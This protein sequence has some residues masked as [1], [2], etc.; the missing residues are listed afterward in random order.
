MKKIC[1]ILLLSAATA[2]AGISEAKSQTNDT[3]H[4]YTDAENRRIAVLFHRG[5]RCDSLLATAEAE[6]VLLKAIDGQR[7]SISR[8]L[9]RM[10]SGADSLVSH[11][12]AE[13]G[14]LLNANKKLSKRNRVKNWFIGGSVGLNLLLLLIL[15]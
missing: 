8:N 4:C 11:L 12:T 9:T 13:N 10:H 1:S 2:S 5:E 7:D 14:K 15:I 6:I 3:L